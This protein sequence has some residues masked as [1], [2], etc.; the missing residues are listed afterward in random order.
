MEAIKIKRK[1][2]DVWVTSFKVW[3]LDKNKC[4]KKF[5]EHKFPDDYEV[6]VKLDNNMEIDY[7]GK[8]QH[9]RIIVEDK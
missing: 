5:L 9:Y 3:E 8:R 6:Y 1:K 7:R 4:S 2:V